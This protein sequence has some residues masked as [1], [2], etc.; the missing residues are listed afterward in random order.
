MSYLIIFFGGGI[1]ATLRHGVNVM[2]TRLMGTAFPFGTLTVNV[3]G[4]LLM[5]LIAGYVAYNGDS[6][7]H[8]RLFLTTA[9]LAATRPSPLSRWMLRSCMNAA[10]SGA[11]QPIR[12]RPY[13]RRLQACSWVYG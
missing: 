3:T 9:S 13:W 7:Q 8:W 1:G 6:S 4:S 11:W 5:G 10:I 2:A 12:W